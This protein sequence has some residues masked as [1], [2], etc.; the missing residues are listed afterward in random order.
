MAAGSVLPAVNYRFSLEISS[1]A[2]TRAIVRHGAEL[3]QH[4][5]ASTGYPHTCPT[6]SNCDCGISS[7]CGC[8]INLKRPTCCFCSTAFAPPSTPIDCTDLCGGCCR[9]GGRCCFCSTALASP[10]TP[11]HCTYRCC[12][13]GGHCCSYSTTPVPPPAPIDHADRCSSSGRCCCCS[14][15]ASAAAVARDPPPAGSTPSPVGPP[16]DGIH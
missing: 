15:N 1:P 14:A 4:L 7:S 11:T 5:T 2:S 16:A 3:V 6:W 8:H 12:R 13:C 9:G 10:S